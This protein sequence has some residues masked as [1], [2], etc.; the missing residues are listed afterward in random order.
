MYF[1][2][3]FF[4]L[5]QRGGKWEKSRKTHYML[6]VVASFFGHLVDSSLF[7]GALALCECVNS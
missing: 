6:H 3:V 7:A 2:V 1:V 4:C 5:A